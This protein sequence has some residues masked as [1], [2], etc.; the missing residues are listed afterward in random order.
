MSVNMAK[1]NWLII[2]LI[3]LIATGLASESLK[4]QDNGELILNPE[5]WEQ[6]PITVYIDDINV[7]DSYSPS[8]RKSVENAL[9][10]WEKGGN[11]QLGYQPDFLIV[12][13]DNADILVMWVKNLE[14]DAGVEDGVAGFARPYVVNGRFERVDIVLETGNSRAY[15]WVQYG[16]KTMQDIAAHEIGHAL[17]LGHSNDRNDIM[18]PTYD[19]REDID[20]LLLKSTWPLIV[21]L[22]LSALVLI[23]YYGTGWLHY[24][25]KRKDLENGVFDNEEKE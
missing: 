20:P 4:H 8:Y 12:D 21:L 15:S 9:E 3:I 10:Y 24:K 5:P 6:M 17:G 1:M 22:I 16:D 25:R 7:P 18:Y 23:A 11:G 13:T 19:S 2:A 14:Q